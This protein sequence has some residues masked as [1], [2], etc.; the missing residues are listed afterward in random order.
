[1]LSKEALEELEIIWHKNNPNKKINKDQLEEMARRILDGVK[2]L[3]KPIP[4][5]EKESC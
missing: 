5:K 3:Y 2:L 1:M 4:V